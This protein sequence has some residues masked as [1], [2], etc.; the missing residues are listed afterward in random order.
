MNFLLLLLVAFLT[1][2]GGLCMQ[3]WLHKRIGHRPHIGFAAIHRIHDGSHH[4]L[5][6]QERY[7]DSE[8][9]T[10]ELS[11]TS[12]FAI[13]VIALLALAAWLLP[14]DILLTALITIASCFWF[15]A[16]VHEHFHLRQSYLLRY[17]WFRRWKA[18]HRVHHLDKTKNFGLVS[19]TCDR[20][21]GTFVPLDEQKDL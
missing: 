8:Y 13:P 17:R 2:F 1:W 7:E 11:V 14:M 16:H 12:T 9:D 21:M 10:R 15:Q 5:Y 6:S 4:S 18:L 19:F 3:A 20:W